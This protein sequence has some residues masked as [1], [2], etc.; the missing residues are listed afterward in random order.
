MRLKSWATQHPVAAYIVLA[1]AWSF[2]IWS[3]LFLV[4]APGGMV[5][6][7]PPTALL[8]AAVGGVGP[9]FSGLVL[10]RLLYGRA[11]SAA[12]TA[13]LRHWR[14][15]WWWL[16]LL[17]I[18][19]LTAL[20]PLLRWLLGYAVDG[21]AML[22]LIVPGL[23]LGLLAGLMEEFGWRGFLLPHLLKRHSPL[24][25]HVAGWG[26]LGRAMARLCRLFRPGRQG[27]GFLAAGAPAGPWPAHGLVAAAD[28]GL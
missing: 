26:D 21:R 16:A 6:N 24:S 2:S 11:G 1:L 7:P 23:G 12:L 18:P 15:G 25:G 27:A 19:A 3:L 13:R 4:I 22:N 17:A 5:H 14:V 20:M 28:L 9:S 8:I 10:T